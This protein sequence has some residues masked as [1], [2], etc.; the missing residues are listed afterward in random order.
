MFH[1]V[2]WDV[3]ICFNDVATCPSVM[4]YFH[5]TRDIFGCQD[6]SNR[7]ILTFKVLENNACIVVLTM[8]TSKVIP[9]VLRPYLV[10]KNF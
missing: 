7:W 5:V 9:F 6:V 2:F 3:A 4:C 10:L 8:T 1:M